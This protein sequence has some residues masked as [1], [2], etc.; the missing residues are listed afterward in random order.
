MAEPALDTATDLVPSDEQDNQTQSRRRVA[1][2]IVAIA[3]A[4][5][6]WWII[7]HIAVVPSTVG[8]ST[9]RARTLLKFAG[10][11][12]SVTVVPTDDKLSGR[13]LVQAP[14]G[15]LYLTWWPVRVSVGSSALSA[16]YT[17]DVAFIIDTGSSGLDL[18]APAGGWEVMPTDAEE[19]L[20]LYYP[21]RTWELLMPDVQN[22]TESQAISAVEGVGLNVTTERGPS[23]TDVA[24]G[25]I[26]YQKP[27]PGL[28]IK[29]GQ[30]AV[31]WVSDGGFNILSGANTGFPY[32]RP[33]SQYGE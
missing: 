27:A 19:M 8:M 10:F 4:I 6:I 15:G 26:Y 2:V 12:T 18:A 29:S 25:R 22:M 20:G 3:I 5:L 11:E 13:V 28:G 23:T 31:L 32:P 1:F 21:P 7:S 33:P 9:G 24:K 16:S 14:A 30:T 17:E